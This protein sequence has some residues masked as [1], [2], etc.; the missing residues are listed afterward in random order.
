MIRNFEILRLK[1]AGM[2]NLGILK[3][4][5]YQER[6]E[7]KLTLRQLARIAEVKAV[8]NFIESYKSQ[9][10]KRL[11]EQYKTFPSFSILDDIYPEWLKEMYNPPT[12][13]F[14]QGNLK[15]L[16]FPKLG[17]VGSREMSKE[18]PKI[19]Y[20]LIEELK[21]SFVI[22]SGLARGVDTSSHVAAIKQQT[23]TIAVIGNG[24]DISY[25]KENRKLQ[26][27]L[28]THELVLSEYLV[29]EPPL[30]FH[31]P[32]RNRIIAGLSRGII[33]VEAKQ[34]SGS[35]ITS[36]Y[37]LEGNREVFA[38]PGDILNR[39]ASGCNQLIQQGAA[40][41]ITN[42]QDILD[43]FYLYGDNFLP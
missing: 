9:D 37:A 2:S 28:A 31:F 30:K 29:G 1:K 26:E 7:A 14:Y 40:K 25:P 19:T 39:N 35:L 32:E 5:D 21:Q 36:R 4:I 20:K 33:V 16:N 18:A 24:L 34:R 3:L 13:L 11:R 17:F 42:G 41:L 22:V 12:L 27:Y 23:P 38:V 15:L 6:H 8:P 10:V 43:E